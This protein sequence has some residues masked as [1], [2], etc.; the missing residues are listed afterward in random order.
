MD[1]SRLSPRSLPVGHETR[2]RSAGSS[3]SRRACRSIRP[4]ASVVAGVIW[5]AFAVVLLPGEWGGAV[6]AVVSA[7]GEES[8][9][10][11]TP[12]RSRPA[13]GTTSLAPE[14]GSESAAGQVRTA[15]TGRGKRPTVEN[16][17]TLPRTTVAETEQLVAAL[18]G[19]GTNEAIPVPVTIG[20]SVIL[21]VP[22]RLGR[23]S[24]TNAEIANIQVV[25]PNEILVN[26]K[27]PGITTVIAWANNERRY[28]DV[29]VQ[30][31]LELL[32]R[33]MRQLSPREEIRVE[34]A[35]TSVVLSGTVSDAA[36]IVKVAEVV[37]AFL[38]E[39]AGVVNLLRLAE[40]HQIMLKVDIAEVNRSGL[41]ELGI[42]FLHLGTSLAVAFFGGTTGSVLSTFLDKDGTTTFDPRTSAVVKHGDNR[43]FLRALEQRGLV[44]FLARPTLIAASGA[45]AHFLVGGEFPVPVVTGGGAGGATAVT[46]VYKPFGVRLDF[47]PTLNDLESINLKISPEVSDL[48][49]DNAVTLSGFRIPSL[50][51]RRTSTVVD[52]R[53]G[54]SLAVG[55]LISSQ[56]RKA[57]SKVPILG[58]IPVLGALFRSTQF[59][60]NET[61]LV[62]FVTPEI[63]K[64]LTEV[65]N[66]E[67]QM[68]T[69]PDEDKEL[70]QIP[71]K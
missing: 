9:A 21:R 63:V 26:G 44:K 27:V 6:P 1:E 29:V 14:K 46:I 16:T 62:V 15:Q 24:V 31:N 49:F 42:D 41:R 68:R 54:Q 71:G 67:Q 2:R 45:S 70:R 60:R 69:T 57:L 32:Q 8:S 18:R 17:P 52:L 51:T 58:D 28:F 66:L 20:A 5:A 12:D 4:I 11:S 55:G 23:A 7:E 50:R 64:P 10:T 38:P 22:G 35:H 48:D 25:P 43:V 19:V 61:D 34:A 3:R 59:V 33:A 40:P 56:D 30:A 39:K 65:P 53:P 47:T 13:R 36:L 37:R